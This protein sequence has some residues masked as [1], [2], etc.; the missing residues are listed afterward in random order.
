MINYYGPE[1]AFL[2]TL[3]YELN[4]DGLSLNFKNDPI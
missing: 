3:E 1:I 2:D 4:K